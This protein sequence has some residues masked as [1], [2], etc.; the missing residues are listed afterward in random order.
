M[1]YDPM[2]HFARTDAASSRG[3]SA[4][5]L[6]K[7]V[8]DN[9]D[10]RRVVAESLGELVKESQTTGEPP[11]PKKSERLIQQ[12]LLLD[13]SD[14]LLSDKTD[15]YQTRETVKALG[16]W[17]ASGR[18]KMPTTPGIDEDWAKELGE[19]AKK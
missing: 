13:L 8:V 6:A 12:T 18:T 5:V 4:M 1:P 2:E 3:K 11:D 7:T 16:A 19:K 17:R 9:S 14:Q 10:L 15:P